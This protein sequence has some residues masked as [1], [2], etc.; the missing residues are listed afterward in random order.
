VEIWKWWLQVRC[1]HV[2]GGCYSYKAVKL[3]GESEMCQTFD[4]VL[5]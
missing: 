3:E 1:Y 4:A 2:T 5:A